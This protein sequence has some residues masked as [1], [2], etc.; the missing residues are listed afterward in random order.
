MALA[1]FFPANLHENVPKN[2]TRAQRND[3][4]NGTWGKGK[5]HEQRRKRNKPPFFKKSLQFSSKAFE[6]F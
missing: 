6:L 4:L 2:I 1:I 5:G 3:K